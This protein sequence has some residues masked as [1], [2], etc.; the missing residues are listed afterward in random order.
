LV[1]T[2]KYLSDEIDHP[3]LDFYIST[4]GLLVDEEALNGLKN[5]KH[6]VEVAFSLDGDPDTINENRT[7]KENNTLSK[8]VITKYLLAK[9]IL[10]RDSVSITMTISKKTVANFEHN[11][12]YL[13]DLNPYLLRFRLSS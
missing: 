4:N 9:K 5:V 7:Q 13:F 1:D 3:N 8:L 2:I 12:L 11:L 6:N 10:G